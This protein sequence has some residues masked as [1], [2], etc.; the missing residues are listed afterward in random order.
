MQKK[1]SPSSKFSTILVILIVCAFAL[2]IGLLL[3]SRLPEQPVEA[4]DA[5]QPT[6]KSKTEFQQEEIVQT[7]EDFVESETSEVQDNLTAQTINGI[8]VRFE[9]VQLEGETVMVNVCFDLPDDSD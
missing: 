4:S 3:K 1:K 2:A 9:G 8:E 6:A 7:A 5:S